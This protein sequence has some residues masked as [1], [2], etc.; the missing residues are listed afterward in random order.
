M[1]TDLPDTSKGVD[2]DPEKYLAGEEQGSLSDEELA[3]L[4]SEAAP[5]QIKAAL[6]RMTPDMRR[7]AALAIGEPE[8]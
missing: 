7:V 5:Q 4:L 1:V 2:A 3:K 8:K 6:P